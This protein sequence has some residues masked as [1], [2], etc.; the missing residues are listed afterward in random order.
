M[1][2]NGFSYDKYLVFP[3][4]LI[5]RLAKYYRELLPVISF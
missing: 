1:G 3:V 5:Y 4:R 2:N